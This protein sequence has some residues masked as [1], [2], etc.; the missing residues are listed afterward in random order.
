MASNL[1]HIFPMTEAVQTLEPSTHRYKRG[2]VREDGLIFWAYE[3]KDKQ[4]WVTSQEFFLRKKKDKSKS[5]LYASLHKEQ[6]A[7][8]KRLYNEKNREKQNEQ[9]KWRK[10]KNRQADKIKR[11]SED[12]KRKKKNKDLIRNFGINIEQYELMLDQQDG[13]CAICNSHSCK[14]GRKF[15][16]DHNHETGQVRAL[17][18]QNCNTALGHFQ[19]S[20]ELL[21]TA[22]SYL[23]THNNQ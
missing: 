22:I 4:R 2:D 3:A 21:L 7:E 1:N 13:K 18:C 17:L 20:Q 8:T 5:S 10:R 9:R 16:V 14:S 12:F 19:D 6:I 11:E 15:A 23:Q